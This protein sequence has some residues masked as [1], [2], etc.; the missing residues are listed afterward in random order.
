MT[1]QKIEPALLE[2]WFRDRYFTAT[3]DISSSGVENY[4]L[5][6]L[7]DL[8]SIDM[9]ELDALPFRDSPSL[10]AWRLRT[11]VARRHPPAVPEQVM[12]THGSSE[13]IFLALAVLVQPGDEVVVVSPAYQSLTSIAAALGAR[14]RVWHLTAGE[15]FRPDPERL[16][17]LIDRRTKAV[18]VNFP[19]NPTGVMPDEAG[20]RALL[21]LV[22]RFGCFLLWDAALGEL[23]YDRDALPD[24][25]HLVER[26]VS[27]GTLS[28]AYGLPGL[29]V[30]WCLADGGT[31]ASM[32]RLR[33]YVTI[34]TSPLTGYLAT[35]VL[36]NAELIASPRREQA[37]RNR[38]MLID[39]YAAQ[40]DLVSALVPD[41]GV[42]AFPRFPRH[43]DVTGLCRRL[44]E[45]HGVLVVPGSCFGHPDR[46]R[47]GFGGP[48]GELQQGLG[49]LSKMLTKGA[50]GEAGRDEHR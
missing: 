10:G 18:I 2:D 26:C 47:I 20:Y 48:A 32:V 39:W 17:G 43:G 16:T 40:G 6:E 50:A 25:V 3:V 38:A 15:G 12:V 8:L 4:S 28:K 46:M 24:P 33:D 19:H 14:V 37:A 49:I 1:L 29:R 5:G 11:A 9:A 27:S 7:R 44:E 45:D 13:A 41:G 30:G 21:E 35:R 36:E 23:V 31:L 34:G 42:T 22:E